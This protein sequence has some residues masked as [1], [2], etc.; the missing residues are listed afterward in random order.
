MQSL[1]HKLRGDK[2]MHVWNLQLHNQE[3]W[4]LWAQMLGKVLTHDESP[5]RAVSAFVEYCLLEFMI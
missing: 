1:G 3:G 2:V 4:S 5:A